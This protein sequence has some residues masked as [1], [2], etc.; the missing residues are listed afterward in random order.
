MIL[1]FSVASTAAFGR[2]RCYTFACISI[3]TTN[4]PVAFQ[5]THLCPQVA[6]DSGFFCCVNGCLCLLELLEGWCTASDGSANLTAPPAS[7]VSKS[8]ENGG[9]NHR[10]ERVHLAKGLKIKDWFS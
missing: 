3:L 9:D 8:Q 7:P 5:T 2:R 10:S 1:A 6:D 4:S